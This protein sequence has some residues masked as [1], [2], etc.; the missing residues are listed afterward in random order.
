MSFLKNIL[1]KKDTPVTTNAEFWQWFSENEQE[2]YT[3]VKRRGN[4]EKDFFAK[5]SPKLNQLK[6]GY[7]Y[8]TGMASD[9]VAELVI[10]ADGVIR[11]F[12]FVQEL[13]AAAPTLKNWKFT[14]LK[15]AVDL[16]GF[17][18]KM[19]PYEF[20]EDTLSF[21][22][23][24]D[25]E[26]PDSVRIVVI[27]QNYSEGDKDQIYNAVYIFLENY[28]GELDLV[29]RIDN[30]DVAESAGDREL[31]PLAKLKA[32]LLW[33][34]K[35]FVEKYE[36]KRYDTENDGHSAI[37][38]QLQ[39]G[40]PLVAIINTDLLRWDSKAS[41]PWILTVEMNY[42]G[43]QGLPDTETYQLLQKIEEE[44]AEQLKDSDGFL[45]IG[46][47]TAANVRE[48]YYACKDYEK[49]SKVMH[50]I[51]EAHK[52]KIGMDHRISKDKYW[53]QFEHFVNVKG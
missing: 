28:L 13:V 25:T 47:Q 14:A 39:N 51:Q 40:D 2:F 23:D 16:D 35:E 48:V 18:I 22:V 3:V 45:N 34:E 27:P 32:L 33:R 36:G 41:H 42:K 26:H 7:F 8:L 19:G 21:Y 10:T 6:D 46:R 30:L 1:G 29:K 52:A 38:G 15:Q 4:I 20:S 44:I 9:D 5:L 37:E 53:Q 49:A 31:I 11:N 12:V 17:S 24:N 43:A 50:E